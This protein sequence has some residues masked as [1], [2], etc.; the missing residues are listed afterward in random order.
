MDLRRPLKLITP[1]VD[2]DVLAVLA[3]AEATFTAPQVHRLIGDHSESGVRKSLKR[4]QREGI[5]RAVR[6]GQAWSYE[7]NRSH[8]AAAHIVALAA[9]RSELIERI[10]AEI[11][12]WTAPAEHAALFGSG[13][14][15][16]MR[17]DSDLDLLV[18]RP[19]EVDANEGVWRDQLDGLA[20][21]VSGWTGND[22]RILEFGASEVAAGL[23]AG[24]ESILEDIRDRGVPVAGPARY[25]HR[26]ARVG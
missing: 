23:R 14:T 11:R 13:A 22:T 6:T 12:G 9:F 20:A 5:V 19:D 25:L 8:L 4:L 21:M 26:V 1:T 2:G 15:G 18:V 10:A 17:S 24:S 16:G 3:G 7:L